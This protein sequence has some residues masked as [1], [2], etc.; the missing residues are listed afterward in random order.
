MNIKLQL[1]F[2]QDCRRWINVFDKRGYL[3]IPLW[4]RKI[5]DDG[6]LIVRRERSAI[7]KPGLQLIAR[8]EYKR[9]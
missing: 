2:G 4:N 9:A 7:G 5:P 8:G 3:R 6:H 1:V